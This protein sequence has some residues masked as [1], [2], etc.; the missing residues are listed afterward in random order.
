[1]YKEGAL[2]ASEN[3]FLKVDEKEEGTCSQ[4]T[5]MSQNK[6]CLQSMKVTM[7]VPTRNETEIS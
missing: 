2:L 7:T 1:M 5:V 4:G 3:K 6:R